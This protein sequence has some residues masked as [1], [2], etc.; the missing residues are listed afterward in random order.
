MQHGETLCSHWIRWPWSALTRSPGNRNIWRPPK[1]RTTTMDLTVGTSVFVLTLWFHEQVLKKETW[2]WVLLCSLKPVLRLALQTKIMCAK[3]MTEDKER[4]PDQ[5]SEL[6]SSDCTPSLASHSV[7]WTD[8][9]RN[10]CRIP[11]PQFPI[12]TCCL[13]LDEI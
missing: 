2:F 10:P 5:I 3:I 1:R 4:N 8:K 7:Q 13:L 9:R 12:S 6:C 11:F